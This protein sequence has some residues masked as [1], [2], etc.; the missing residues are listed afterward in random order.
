[1]QIYVIVL[2]I[3]IKPNILHEKYIY[4]ISRSNNV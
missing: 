4:E 3:I 2:I 1:M